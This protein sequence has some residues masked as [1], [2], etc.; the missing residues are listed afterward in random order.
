MTIWFVL[1]CIS[2]GAIVGSVVCYIGYRGFLFM[3]SF[4][5][6]VDEDAEVMPI[7][8]EQKRER[9]KQILETEERDDAW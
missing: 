1:K 8:E 5:T 7:T 3:M 4:G 2:I 9:R 6:H